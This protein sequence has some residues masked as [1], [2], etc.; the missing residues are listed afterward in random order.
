MDGPVQYREQAAAFLVLT[1]ERCQSH[2]HYNADPHNNAPARRSHS[3]PLH[4]NLF[5]KAAI[6]RGNRR[7]A[8]F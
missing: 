4:R 7:A 8:G 1:L 2:P 6:L 5:A 3:V